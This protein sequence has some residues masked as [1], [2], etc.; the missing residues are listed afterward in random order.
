MGIAYLIYYGDS[1]GK[2]N[3]THRVRWD[4]HLTYF[5]ARATTL[6]RNSNSISYMHVV[7]H[8][9]LLSRLYVT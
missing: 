5:K 9:D 3:W 7:C 6:L 4:V 2:S 1:K 8:F